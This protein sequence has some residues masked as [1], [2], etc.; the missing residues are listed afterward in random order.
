MYLQNKRVE[1]VGLYISPVGFET[2]THAHKTIALGTELRGL[3]LLIRW[4][5]LHSKQVE[6]VQLYLSPVGFEPTSYASEYHRSNHEAK[7]TD[8]FEDIFSIG[9][10][11]TSNIIVNMI[12]ANDSNM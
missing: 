9:G 12:R 11:N 2:T 5:L 4:S 1:H 8:L 6:H 3:M 10:A 7:R